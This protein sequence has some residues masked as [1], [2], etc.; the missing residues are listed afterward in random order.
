MPAKHLLF[1]PLL[2]APSLA[3]AAN[4]CQPGEETV[5]AF[6]TPSGK[7]LSLCKGKNSAWLA[8]R[9]G[10]PGAVELQFPDKLDATS[11]QRF[12]F[13]GL[14]RWGGKANAGFGDYSLAFRAGDFAYTVF[15]G[16]DDEEGSYGI[17]VAVA[18]KGKSVT[19]AG[20]KKSQ[21]GSL[22]NLNDERERLSNRAE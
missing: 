20:L 12:E 6:A 22:L 15:Q 7:L 2:A 19:L 21:E 18:G 3:P 9:F 14:H 11:W 10:K 13:S 1:A 8:Y 4:L 17:G 5:F 16:W